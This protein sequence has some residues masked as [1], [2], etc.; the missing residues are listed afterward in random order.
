MNSLIIEYFNIVGAF[1]AFVLG[2]IK[3]YDHYKDRPSLSITYGNFFYDY[4][5]GNTSFHM[6]LNLINKGRRPI[7]IVNILVD[8]L[9]S[10]DDQLNIHSRSFDIK[11]RLAPHG[12]IDKSFCY[13]V[14]KKLP[15]KSYKL[16]LQIVTSYKT[17]KKIVPIPYF[18][19]FVEPVYK[20]ISEGVKKGF[21]E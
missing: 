17:Y 18:D 3:I 15:K 16:K 10:D 12:F 13:E 4:N 2:F 20:E 11:T 8:L 6:A 1:V 14:N 5:K 7:F 19:D 9:K 21:I